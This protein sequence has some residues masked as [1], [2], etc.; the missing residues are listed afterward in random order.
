VIEHLPSK[1]KVLSSNPRTDNNTTQQKTFQPTNWL[2]MHKSQ[3]RNIIRKKGNM[4]APKVKCSTIQGLNDSEVDKISNSDLK[5]T[6]ARM[7]NEIKEDMY[8]HLN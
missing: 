2:Q 8:K 6:M 3:L 4:S 5:R 7:V 1:Y